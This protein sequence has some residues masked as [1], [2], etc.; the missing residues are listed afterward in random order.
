[1]SQSEYCLLVYR[2]DDLLYTGTPN[3]AIRWHKNHFAGRI[4]RDSKK[5]K[6]I[7]S[8]QCSPL[9]PHPTQLTRQP[10]VGNVAWH[11]TETAIVG[12]FL[13]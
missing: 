3:E 1:M 2:Y 13:I 9:P 4:W 6:R 5:G 8:F 12:F 10:L 11:W 7:M